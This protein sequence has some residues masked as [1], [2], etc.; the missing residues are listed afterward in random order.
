MSDKLDLILQRLDKLDLI[1]IELK[2][3]KAD[4]KATNARLDKIDQ[5]LDKIESDLSATKEMVAA[6]AE[7]VTTLKETV[8]TG[9]NDLVNGQELLVQKQFEYEKDLRLL[10]KA[11]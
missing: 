10:K 11:K 2:E 1:E 9:F 5:R 7:D 4:Q 6:T 8:E 3:M